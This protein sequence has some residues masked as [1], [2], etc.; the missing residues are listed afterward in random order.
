MHY[1]MHHAMHYAM[2][3]V[4]HY[5]MHHAMHDGTQVRVWAVAKE[6]Q[7]M[8]ASMKEHKGPVYAIAIKAD[9]SECVSASADGS[10]ITWA[11]AGLSSFTRINV[12]TRTCTCCIPKC[13][14]S[15]KSPMRPPIPQRLQCPH[16]QCPIPNA[17]IPSAPISMPPCLTPRSQCPRSPCPYSHV[18]MP[19]RPHSQCPLTTQALFAANFFKSVLYH[20]DESQ[21]LTCG[22]DR[23]L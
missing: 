5:A 11:L 7:V 17:P 4:M 15:P 22:T 8:V 18:P 3:Y 19:Q 12:S 9:D 2:H 16:S 1:V 20:P 23:K 14:Q 10:C 13:P 6:T 21:L